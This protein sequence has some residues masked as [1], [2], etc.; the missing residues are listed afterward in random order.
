VRRLVGYFFQGFVYVAPLG[1]TLY[2]VYRIFTFVDTPLRQIERL[3]LGT[4]IP[5]L[6]VVT[7]IVLLTLLG[8]LG[9]TIIARPVKAVGRRILERAPLIGMIEG[10]VR[11]LLTALFSRERRF[12]QPVIVR[13]SQVSDLEKVGFIT[14]EDLGKLG[15]P[16]KVAV[17]FPH[18]YNFSGELFLVP[19][20]RI[21]VLDISA[22]EALKFVVSGGMIRLGE[23]R[24]AAVPRPAPRSPAVLPEP[25]AGGE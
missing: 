2:I 12:K 11:D 16:G 25:P 7:V 18:S 20:D 1:V 15:S 19:R 9:S 8:W 6:G 4:H 23:E 14:Q 17:Y 22:Q 13:V 21:R 24:E 10:A 3:F 5:G